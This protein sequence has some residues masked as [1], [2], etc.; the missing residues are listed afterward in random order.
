MGEWWY[1]S[2][3]LYLGT[4][5]K[6]RLKPSGNNPFTHCG[7]FKTE[8]CKPSANCLCQTLGSPLSPTSARLRPATNN[9]AC[10]FPRHHLSVFIDLIIRSII[11]FR[12]HSFCSIA[13]C[14][15]SPLQYHFEMLQ[16]ALA[17]LTFSLC[18]TNWKQFCVQLA[19]VICVVTSCIM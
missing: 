13:A 19:F 7:C 2:T 1:S 3:R 18:T 9:T 12:P 8:Q 17:I 5:C 4:R 16:T 14:C 11:T 10:K 6:L 15:P